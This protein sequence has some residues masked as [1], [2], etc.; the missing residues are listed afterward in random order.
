MG[1]IEGSESGHARRWEMGGAGAAA[2][3]LVARAPRTAGGSA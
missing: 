3:G 1:L 2:R